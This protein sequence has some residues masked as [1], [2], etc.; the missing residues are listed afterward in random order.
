MLTGP[1]FPPTHSRANPPQSMKFLKQAPLYPFAF[2]AYPV[3]ALLAVNI[4]QVD[5]AVVLRPLAAALIAAGLIF[6]GLRWLT[7]DTA[8]AALVASLL[9]L[10]FFSYGHV[11][12]FLKLHAAALARHRYLGALYLLILLGGLWW[13]LRRIKTPAAATGALNLVGAVL[14]VLPLLQLGNFAVRTTIEHNTAQAAAANEQVQLHPGEPT[15]TLPDVYFIVLD[16]HTRA[17][18]LKRDFDLDISPFEDQLRGMGFYVVPC[19]RPNYTYTEA[20]VG[21]ALNMDYL[22]PIMQNA[23]ISSQDDLW[24]LMQHS[25]IRKQL[26]AIGYKTVA[27]E[28]GF[29]WTQLTDADYYLKR[30]NAGLQLAPFESMLFDSTAL[31]AVSDAD[32]LLIKSQVTHPFIDHIQRELYVLD[33]LPKVPGLPSPKFVFVHILIPHLPFVF[34]PDGEILTDPGYFKAPGDGPVDEAHKYNGYRGQVQFIDSRMLPILKSILDK[35]K[36]P[37]IIV[38]MGDHGIDKRNRTQNLETVYL[39]NGG[40]SKLYPT[41]TPVNIFRIIFDNYFGANYPLLPD[42]TFYNGKLSKETFPDCLP[43]K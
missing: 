40:E 27:F 25:E 33:E 39:P 36:T 16:M 30:S 28:T 10:L 24:I 6:L 41:L 17:D 13:M 22:G 19:S 11:Y 14:I 34:G 7:K 20:S 15:S 43:P 4:K 9:L 18:A 12:D 26:E 21:T 29:A 35:S 38:M 37:P 32:T 2:A 5:A 31:S 23:G 42:Q 3:L 1:G 8:R